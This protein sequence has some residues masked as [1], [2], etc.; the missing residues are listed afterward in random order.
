MIYEV[1]M[2]F[3]CTFFEYFDNDYS[4]ECLYSFNLLIQYIIY[5]FAT[6]NV[7]FCKEIIYDCKEKNS[8]LY[9]LFNLDKTSIRSLTYIF[10]NKIYS[11]II[12]VTLKKYYCD[13]IF[14]FINDLRNYNEN[15]NIKNLKIIFEKYIFD[16]GDYSINISYYNRYNLINKYNNFININ[17]EN[18]IF[19][20]KYF[21]FV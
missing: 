2:S 16:S 5:Y 17:K 10:L 8:D 14:M 6:N 21:K 18:D 11:F 15:K 1:I 7:N 13:E 20:L 12:E 9:L 19:L 4:I 3:H